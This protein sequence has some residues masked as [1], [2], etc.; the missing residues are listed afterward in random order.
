MQ[1]LQDQNE[2]KED[3]TQLNILLVKVLINAM[4]FSLYGSFVYFYI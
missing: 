1:E 3:T 2:N 4:G